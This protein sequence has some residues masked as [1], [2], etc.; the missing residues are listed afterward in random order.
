MVGDALLDGF[1]S[2][3]TVAQVGRLARRAAPIGTCGIECLHCPAGVSGIL[4]VLAPDPRAC[5]AAPA[6]VLDAQ[7]SLEVPPVG[8]G[9]F[10]SE[11]RNQPLE[12]TLW[13]EGWEDPLLSVAT[14]TDWVQLGCA[15]RHCGVRTSV[16]WDLGLL[17]HAAH[18]LECAAGP[19]VAVPVWRAL[20]APPPA[21]REVPGSE[22][23]AL[24]ARFWEVLPG[25]CVDA[26]WDALEAA[27]SDFHAA[28]ACRR[29][30]RG[31][32]Q[33]VSPRPRCSGGT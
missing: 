20:A 3:A 24:L 17:V 28:A 33:R 15:S 30:V 12:A 13:Q 32:P 6:C 7:R 21:V 19:E 23:E 2:L 25:G 16:C 31:S 22:A 27:A 1:S 9:D 18:E 5:A 11:L 8:L 14:R 26:V 29:Y 4:R 10:S